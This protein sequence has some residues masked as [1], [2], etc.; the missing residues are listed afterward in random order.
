LCTRAPTDL[1]EKTTLQGGFLF[2]VSLCL[3]G[4]ILPMQASRFFSNK[5]TLVALVVLIGAS[6][7]F[8]LLPLFVGSAPAG[9]GYTLSPNDH[10]STWQWHGAYLDGAQKESDTKKEIA[11]LRSM[12][13]KG[14][15]SDYELYIG[16]ASQYELL[17]DGKSA[18]QYLSG[19]IAK[20]PKKGLAYMNMGH[21][22]EELGAF[23]TAH[24]AYD[25]A[26]RLEPTNQ[27]FTSSQQNFLIHHS[28][29]T[30]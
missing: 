15:V 19:A 16:I 22:M 30:K 7:L 20:E 24:Q 8:V 5:L 18:Y 10:I 26:V 11:R 12:F 25:E 1:K 17:G 9:A 23:T 6:A 21:L 3:R 2:Q 13:G 14:S 27:A 29:L 4:S 28:G